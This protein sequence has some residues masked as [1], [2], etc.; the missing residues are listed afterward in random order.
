MTDPQK[1]HAI[2]DADLDSADVTGGALQR[3][4]QTVLCNNEVVEVARRASLDDG[5]P[6]VE[7]A[8]K[9]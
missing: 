1:P 4:Q 9:I 5:Q 7:V 6:L 3:M 2:S 8:R